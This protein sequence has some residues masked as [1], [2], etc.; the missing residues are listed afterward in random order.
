MR[1]GS[2]RQAGA[3]RLD[4]QQRCALNRI[5]VT[6][7]LLAL[8]AGACLAPAALANPMRN[9]DQQSGDQQSGS[10]QSGD[11]QQ[12]GDHGKA[13]T[14]TLNSG[15]TSYGTITLKQTKRG[16]KVTET[17]AGGAVFLA[18]G[19][20]NALSFN[21]QKATEISGLPQTFSPRPGTTG[22]D[23]AGSFTDTIACSRCGDGH[24]GKLPDRLK[25]T[26]SARDGQLTLADFLANADNAYF[27]SDIGIAKDGTV[28]ALG[29]VAVLGTTSTQAVAQTASSSVPVIVTSPSLAGTAVP[30]PAGLSLLASGVLGLLVLR[31]RRA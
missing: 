15:G 19:D 6:A 20:S 16:V 2:G 10:R 3:P 27:A 12:A 21:I 5:H 17:L 23:G 29:N 31:R 24:D 7:V 4:C 11:Q 9:G 1:R 18:G 8:V 25:F 26:V 14:Y 30:E 13:V 28:T 22:A